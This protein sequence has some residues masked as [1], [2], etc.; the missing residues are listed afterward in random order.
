MTYNNKNDQE[1]IEHAVDRHLQQHRSNGSARLSREM[2]DATQSQLRGR[3]SRERRGRH[4]PS[5]V[6]RRIPQTGTSK[7][8]CNEEDVY[9]QSL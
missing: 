4:D 6:R 2:D 5:P 7:A 3:L 9:A 8:S 1:C